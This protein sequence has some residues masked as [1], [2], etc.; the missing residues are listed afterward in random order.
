MQHGDATAPAATLRRACRSAA[1]CA[2]AN[3]GDTGRFVERVAAQQAAIRTRV[4]SAPA[5][6]ADA[7]L[8]A[9]N[10]TPATHVRQLVD[11]AG[12][13]IPP[14]VFG[15]FVNAFLGKT[16]GA[17]TGRC[18]RFPGGAP[19]GAPADSLCV[20]IPPTIEDNA[21]ALRASPVPSSGKRRA[22]LLWQLRMAVHEV[23]DAGRRYHGR[24]RLRPRHHRLPWPAQRRLF[25]PVLPQRDQRHHRG[26]PRLLPKRRAS[27]QRAQSAS[28][29]G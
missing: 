14:Q 6:T 22:D 16:V 17:Q 26:V 2:G 3:P 8:N 24:R 7:A 27:Q 9:R 23:R 19:T 4:Q 12:I 13:E 18:A 5:G 1:D 29:L 10:R 25:R 20:Q 28:A 11:D 15:F 21:A